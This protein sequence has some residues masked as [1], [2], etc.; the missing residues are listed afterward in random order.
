[1]MSMMRCTSWAFANSSSG[2]GRARSAKTLPLLGS[3][4]GPFPM[5]LLCQNGI[6]GLVHIR[7]PFAEVV[8]L[9]DELHESQ[10]ESMLIGNA[11]SGAGAP[12]NSTAGSSL[13]V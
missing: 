12:G 6:E 1:M 8:G 2:F 3:I 5:R 4:L 10:L 9:V 11:R 13:S 7:I